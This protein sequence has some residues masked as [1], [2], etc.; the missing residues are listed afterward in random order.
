[1][2]QQTAT[3]VFSPSPSFS[4]CHK[5]SCR[6]SIYVYT[7]NISLSM[8]HTK[9]DH[10]ETVIDIGKPVLHFTGRL[11]FA[12]LTYTV[13]KKKKIEKKWRKQEVASLVE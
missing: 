6:R 10:R 11:E 2:T 8:A 13:T 4:L 5:K 3:I 12:S 1:M 9:S 7:Y